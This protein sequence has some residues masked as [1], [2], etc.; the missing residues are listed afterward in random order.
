MAHFPKTT[1]FPATSLF[2]ENWRVSVETTLQ[3]FAKSFQIWANTWTED[4]FEKIRLTWLQRALG[5][6]QMI[7]VK[8]E[9]T[10]LK[11]I[12]KDLDQHGALVLDR[13]GNVQ[14]ITAG[15]VYFPNN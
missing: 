15:E 5:L 3:A 4:G 12:F 11:G 9:N 13:N 1:V 10:T 7:E 6:G 14:R 2:A 8:L